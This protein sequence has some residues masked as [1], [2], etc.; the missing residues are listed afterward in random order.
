MPE[1]QIKEALIRFNVAIKNADGAA[2]SAALNELESL[3]ALHRQSLHPRLVH[4]LEGRSYAKALVWLD[5]GAEYVAKP[6]SPPG[7]CGRGR[8]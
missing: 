1:T 4:F 7:G 2:L 5:A 8:P 3:L 6:A